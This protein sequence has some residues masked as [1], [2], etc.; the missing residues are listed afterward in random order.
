MA[1]DHGDSTLVPA[2]FPKWLRRVLNALLPGSPARFRSLAARRG[3]CGIGFRA[4]LVERMPLG[5][6]HV[7]GIATG[8]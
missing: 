5:A 8:A 3:E 7:V 6:L 1:G 4:A 2:G